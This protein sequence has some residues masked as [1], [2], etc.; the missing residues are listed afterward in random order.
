MTLLMAAKEPADAIASSVEEVALAQS[1]DMDPLAE[2]I[3][4]EGLCE[5]F[6]FR[7]GARRHEIRRE[8]TG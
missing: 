1:G 3:G 6:R 8:A 7:H 2:E 4:D 5:R